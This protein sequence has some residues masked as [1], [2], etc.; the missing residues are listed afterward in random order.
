MVSHE[1][2][3]QPS[4]MVEVMLTTPE[5]RRPSWPVMVTI[6]LGDSIPKPLVSPLL[7]KNNEETQWLC[8]LMGMIY[9]DLSWFIQKPLD[10]PHHLQVSNTSTFFGGLLRLGCSIKHVFLPTIYSCAHP[11]HY[12]QEIGVKR[13]ETLKP[14]NSSKNSGFSSQQCAM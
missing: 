14:T 9:H 5:R 1:P 12:I 3:P 2:F 10:V 13:I 6:F 7:T 11:R 4:H 8:G